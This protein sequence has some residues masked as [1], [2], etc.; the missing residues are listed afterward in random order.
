[1]TAAA[2]SGSF[3]DTIW[4]RILALIIAILLAVFIWTNWGDYITA[5][6][7]GSEVQTEAQK[8]EPAKPANPELDACL[9]KRVGDVDGMK[10]QGILTEAQYAQ[11]RARA[12]ALCNAQ[13]SG[14]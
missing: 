7:A 6:F 10:E 13:H 4:M 12:E 8:A 3:L 11:F 1:M 2:Q 9:E 5:W 14:G